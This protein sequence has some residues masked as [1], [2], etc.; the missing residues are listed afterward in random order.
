MLHGLQ[1]KISLMKGGSVLWLFCYIILITK[2]QAD[3]VEYACNIRTLL[4][5]TCLLERAGKKALQKLAKCAH[6][7]F[8]ADHGILWP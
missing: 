8:S 6:Y 5:Q 4:K 3:D 7:H 2:L 1:G